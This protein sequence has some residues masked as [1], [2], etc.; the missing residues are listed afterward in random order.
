[1]LDKSRIYM[2]KS[3]VEIQ[4]LLLK[5]Q[6]LGAGQE[7]WIGHGEKK[8]EQDAVLCAKLH[9]K[10]LEFILYFPNFFLLYGNDY[11]QWLTGDFPWGLSFAL[12]EHRERC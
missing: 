10:N 3:E 5:F 8:K 2:L 6:T 11:H 1:M 12:G 9:I 4:K 7:G